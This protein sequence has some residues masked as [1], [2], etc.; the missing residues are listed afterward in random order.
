[1]PCDGMLF[2]DATKMHCVLVRAY[3]KRRDGASQSTHDSV[4]NA[5]RDKQKN[6]QPVRPSINQSLNHMSQSTGFWS[7]TPILR[8]L[9]HAG[10][11]Q[12]EHDI[13]KIKKHPPTTTPT[14]RSPENKTTHAGV[15]D[16]AG[17][18]LERNVIC[19]DKSALRIFGERG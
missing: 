13:Q 2:W 14:I 11:V 4:R 10:K 15:N 12:G 7:V 6:V 18:G 1:M 9:Q 5:I 19:N 16:S 3:S 17:V 8:L